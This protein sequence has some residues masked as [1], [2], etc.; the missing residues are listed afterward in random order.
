[1]QNAGLKTENYQL[2]QQPSE[3][4]PSHKSLFD[5]RQKNEQLKQSQ[6]KN[7]EKGLEIQGKKNLSQ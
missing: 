2:N 7:Q 5:Y 6:F 3:T 1:M 4:L